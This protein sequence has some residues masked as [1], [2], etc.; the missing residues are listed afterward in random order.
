MRNE[1]YKVP[2]FSILKFK[3]S[4]GIKEKIAYHDELSQGVIPSVELLPRF[5]IFHGVHYSCEAFTGPACLFIKIDSLRCFVLWI[6]NLINCDVFILIPKIL[7]PTH[8]KYSKTVECLYVLQI[9]L[10]ISV[11]WRPWLLNIHVARS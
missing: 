11:N 8:F 1:Q 3:K 5:F 2:Y 9:G 7:I 4:W 10:M 6:Q